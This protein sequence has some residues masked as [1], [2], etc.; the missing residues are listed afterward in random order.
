MD[1]GYSFEVRLLG[2]FRLSRD[3]RPIELPA[4]ARLRHLLAYLLLH[5]GHPVSRQQLAFIFWPDTSEEQAHANLRNSLH[6]LRAAL[7]D[8]AEII[9]FDRHHVWPRAEG[10][11]RLDV[12]EFAAGLAAAAAAETS[13]DG[14]TACR[15][16]EAALACYE[17]DLLPD[18]YDDWIIAERERL[19]QAY[20]Q[21]LDRLIALLEAQRALGAAVRHA[22]TLAREDPLDETVYRRLMELQLAS[23]NRAEALRAYHACAALLR[24][25]L[26]VDPSAETQALYLRALHA[27]AIPSPPPTAP[28]LPALVGRQTEWLQLLDFWRRAAAGRPQMALLIGETGIGKTRLAEE[29]LEWAERRQ[30]MTALARCNPTERALAYAPLAALLRTPALR[31]RLARLAPASLSEVSRLLPELTAAPPGL[32]PPGPMTEPWQRQRFFQV[33]VQA[34]V[35]TPSDAPLLLCIDDLQWADSDT[36]DWLPYLLETAGS[37]PLAVLATACCCEL[38]S[39]SPL[40]ALRSALERRGRLTSIALAP[41]PPA[42]ATELAQ[43]TAGRSFAPE[44]AA[45]LYRETEGNPLFVV[46]MARAGP[47]AWSP[48]PARRAASAASPA[49]PPLPP[50]VEAA[51]RR[52]LAGLS[53]AAR[54]LAGVAAVLGRT[55]TVDILTRL[56][57]LSED[58]ILRGLDELWRQQIVR[59]QV[60]A[61][62]DFAHDKLRAVAYADLSPA[63]RRQLHRRAAEALAAAAPAAA[64]G[65]LAAQIARHCLAAGEE[66]KAAGYFEQA[67]D[68]ARLLYAHPEAIAHY[69]Q[70]IALQRRQ[71]APQAAARTLM[72]LGLAHHNAFAYA[73]AQQAYEAAFELWRHAPVPWLDRS[74]AE[75]QTLRTHWGALTTLDPGLVGDF[76]TVAI[77]EELFVGLADHGPDAEAMPALAAGWEVE[78]GGR[79]YVFHLRD[80]LRWS[81]GAALTAED[82]VAG[83]RRVLHPA[84]HASCANFLLDVRGARA[85]LTGETT[86]ETA[87]GVR[88][89]DAHTV[90]VELEQPAAYF[91]HLLA[92]P[93]TYPIPRHALAA[94]GAAWA[95]PA[96]LVCNGPYRLE[97]WQRGDQMTLTRNP[98]YHAA[99]AGNIG[100]VEL[101]LENSAVEILAAYEADALDVV[102]LDY[103]FS[104]AERRAVRD[105]HAGDLVYAPRFTTWFLGFDP[106]HAPLDDGR[107][108][109]ALAMAVD[110]EL[111]A[112]VVLQ[113][114]AAP[115]AGGLTPPGIPGHLKEIGLPYDPAA[116]RQLLAEAGFAA[117]QGFPTLPFACEQTVADQA[118]FLRGQWR[119]HLGIEVALEPADWPTYLQRLKRERLPIYYSAWRADYP[120][121][122]NFL[123]VALEWRKT[124]PDDA[125]FVALVARGRSLTDPAGR[126]AAYAQAERRLI[127]QAFIV[128]LNYRRACFLI[129]PRVTRYPASGLRPWFWQDVVIEPA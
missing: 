120:D 125:E 66:D 88:A 77:V 102:Q 3:G 21:G 107:V 103:R 104:L 91:P 95:E 11:V 123:R 51:I 46:E 38:T 23:G 82:F 7:Q 92:N 10:A 42:A 32:P 122:D 118:E 53:P 79:R 44:Q 59:E 45:A 37:A 63:R 14:P 60:G 39:D 89:A 57:A 113:G 101:A 86:D 4:Q 124:Q 35:G 56:C 108:R 43:A 84:T 65:A 1:V 83:W 9:A 100:R 62:Y 129:K 116:A 121:P 40:E 69:E 50:K 74:R 25:E 49:D 52:R 16:F 87:I 31:R 71:A 47:Q 112:G 54:D 76:N 29:L 73:Q 5:R 99:L 27:D 90:I 97:R 22:Q 78:D 58:A 48:A 67:G 114:F 28:P 64:D 61:A 24:R 126:L 68:Q 2:G 15:L 81:D 94:Y 19:R 20:L 34:M 80:G 127:E 6:R 119:K 41:L 105:R 8:S 30:Q 128:P 26:G 109:R 33:L 18:C 93:V 13:G 98:R 17:G 70:A 111:L 75:L 110:R 115:A 72:K 55:F 85:F 106:T 96:H 12:A 117:G 36:L